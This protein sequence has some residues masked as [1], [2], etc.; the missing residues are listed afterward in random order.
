[1][2]VADGANRAA[3]WAG[4]HIQDRSALQPRPACR[5]LRVRKSC[6]ETRVVTSVRYVGAAWSQPAAA[7]RRALAVSLKSLVFVEI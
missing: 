6:V 7:L 2:L 1:M 5:V 3:I 4:E